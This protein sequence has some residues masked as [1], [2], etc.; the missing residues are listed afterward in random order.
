M[1]FLGPCLCTCVR[2]GMYACVYMSMFLYTDNVHS[3]PISLSVSLSS[4]AYIAVF[5]GVD[6]R[7]ENRIRNM[8]DKSLAILCH[9]YGSLTSSMV[10]WRPE[11]RKHN[12]QVQLTH[13]PILP[14]RY[15]FQFVQLDNKKNNDDIMGIQYNLR[16]I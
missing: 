9:I 8:R 3:V 10:Q 14:T 7:T 2:I 5:R 4:L 16:C 11:H 12:I 1:F 15:T 13:A 6:L